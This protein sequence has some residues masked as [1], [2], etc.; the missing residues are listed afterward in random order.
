MLV[1]HLLQAVG[2]LS[3]HLMEGALGRLVLVN[4]FVSRLLQLLEQLL[5]PA[6]QLQTESKADNRLDNYISQQVRLGRAKA[7]LLHR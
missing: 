5:H 2:S 1:P 4:Q 3:L 6:L 7:R